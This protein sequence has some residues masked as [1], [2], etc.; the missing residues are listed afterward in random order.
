MSITL[1]PLRVRVFCTRSL[2]PKVLDYNCGAENVSVF[3]IYVLS[4]FCTLVSLELS[5]QAG[6]EYLDWQ[7]WIGRFRLAWLVEQVNW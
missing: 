4:C 5:D 1:F 3:K 2:V 6:L 7:R